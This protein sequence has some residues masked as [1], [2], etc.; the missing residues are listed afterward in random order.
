[1][2]KSSL[3]GG[4][5]GT[6]R[7]GVFPA[8]LRGAVSS[9]GF[10][11]FAVTLVVFA[12]AVDLPAGLSALA[13]AACFVLAAAL[14]GY[15]AAAVFGRTGGVFGGQAFLPGTSFAAYRARARVAE[16][17]MLSVS[18]LLLLVSFLSDRFDF[19]MSMSVLLSSSALS[20]AAFGP[21]YVFVYELICA[22]SA[23]R[24]AGPSCGSPA[25][26][27]SPSSLV[28]MSDATD[29]TILSDGAVFDKRIL[30]REAFFGGRTYRGGDLLSGDLRHPASDVYILSAAYQAGGGYPDAIIRDA[31][32]LEIFS[33]RLEAEK[34]GAVSGISSIKRRDNRPSP[35]DL[36][37]EIGYSGSSSGARLLSGVFSPSVLLS[38]SR[39][40]RA[41]GGTEP[42]G[43]VEI[44][45]ASAAAD[46]MRK[47]GAV[48][49]FVVSTAL[50]EGSGP[51]ILEC[52][53]GVGGAFP[54]FNRE[55]NSAGAE[56]GV[57][58]RPGS[59]GPAPVSDV[60]AACVADPGAEV[61][62]GVTFISVL[63]RG[64]ETGND[65]GGDVGD[66]SH[67]LTGTASSPDA[68]IPPVDAER[69][70]GGLRSLFE[71]VTTSCENAVKL[72]IFENYHVS[73]SVMLALSVV[74]PVL[75]GRPS[76]LPSAAV[77]FVALTVLTGVAAASLIYDT[78]FPRA[79][80]P[81]LGK[82][83]AE[84]LLLFGAAGALSGGALFAVP[85]LFLE[86]GAASEAFVLPA[87]VF[88]GISMLF[89]ARLASRRQFGL[90]G[91]NYVQIIS[92]TVMLI[93][94]LLPVLAG[95]RLP[96]IPGIPVAREESGK[97]FLLSLIPCAVSFAAEYAAAR[98]SFGRF[99]EEKKKNG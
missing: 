51:K 85:A 21:S 92:F 18:G 83:A 34:S 75:F 99:S 96:G 68:A 71:L 64:E 69:A 20:A 29:V 70:A 62:E 97:V 59:G 5:G 88:S 91:I 93:A 35:G 78:F 2:K 16:I 48:P 7:A 33:E 46:G 4:T 67:R 49:F 13:A 54:P 32:A 15:R 45:D 76:S 73:A 56:F 23:S 25:Y 95:G 50:P 24:M 79:A 87:A 1:M 86:A 31:R 22:S 9:P 30:V 81:G 66:G 94:A 19:D 28:R 98:L 11:I 44:S 12:A 72:F 58:F 52:V 40:R 53:L 43:G 10:I 37:L 6:R 63:P 89:A 57:R 80:L 41:D 60:S 77:L 27:S 84:R 47:N 14:S 26:V 74:L 61:P 82:K 42:I 8:A 65:G 39:R 38:C 90:S 55:I 36:G 3:A 17:V